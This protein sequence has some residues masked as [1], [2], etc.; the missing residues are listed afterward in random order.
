MAGGGEFQSAVTARGQHSGGKGVAPEEVGG[1]RLILATAACS[2]L[3]LYDFPAFSEPFPLHVARRLL[4]PFPP[5]GEGGWRRQKSVFVV[6]NDA[7]HANPSGADEESFTHTSLAAVVARMRASIAFSLPPDLRG[8][9]FDCPFCEFTP[10][11]RHVSDRWLLKRRGSALQSHRPAPASHTDV[12]QGR[13]RPVSADHVRSAAGLS[14]QCSI[15]WST[16][17]HL[18]LGGP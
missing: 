11:R 8:C 6:T 7:S 15:T 5:H 12:V 18:T 14:K 10:S 4:R 9:L 1:G 2:A 16:V 17:I 3:L 13:N